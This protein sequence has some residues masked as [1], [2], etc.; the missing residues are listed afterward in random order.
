LDPGGFIT[1]ARVA[2]VQGRRGEVAADLH[3]DFPERFAQRRR[4]FAL[5]ADGTRR[6][7][8]VESQRPHKGRMVLKFS[9]VD[10]IS[11]AEALLGAELQV[12]RDERA[13]L[14]PGEA[15]ISDLVGCTVL[16]CGRAIG[17]IAEVQFGAGDAPL[18]VVKS[19]GHEYLVPFAREYLERVDLAASKVEMMLPEG[20][21]EL[22]SPLT[23][24]EKREQRE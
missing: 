14:A 22:E 9:G 7:L 17:R 4:L 19:G 10:S 2:R 1:V 12:Q 24:E 15:Y 23:N 6:E 13:E 3:T 20:M 11:D 18:L 21:L 8:E 16:D 5:A